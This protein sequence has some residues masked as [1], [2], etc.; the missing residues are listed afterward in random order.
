MKKLFVENQALKDKLKQANDK[1]DD[2]NKEYRELQKQHLL[3]QNNMQAY[4][5]GRR[6]SQMTV[7]TMGFRSEMRRS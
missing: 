4:L 5:V 3:L 1:I 7:N 6:G 2:M